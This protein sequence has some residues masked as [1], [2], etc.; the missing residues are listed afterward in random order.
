MFV[1]AI[2]LK[3]KEKFIF[4]IE[5]VKSFDPSDFINNG[6]DRENDYLVFFSENRHDKPDFS[7]PVKDVINGRGCYMVRIFK[8]FGMLSHF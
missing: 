6:V 5:W 7:L 4:P 8:L 2:N 3:S 1:A